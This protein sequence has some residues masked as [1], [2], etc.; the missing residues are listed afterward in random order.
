MIKLKKMNL[1]SSVCNSLH[2]WLNILLLVCE[3][4]EIYQFV[5]IDHYCISSLIDRIFQSYSGLWW[6]AQYFRCWHRLLAWSRG[7]ANVFVC[8]SG[9]LT[10]HQHN[11]AIGARIAKYY[12]VWP[13][14]NVLPGTLA[15]RQYSWFKWLEECTTHMPLVGALL[16][17]ISE[18]RNLLL[19]EACD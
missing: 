2:S 11:M 13:Q 9:F 6:M 10:A 15:G 3:I 19:S 12:S 16:R 14:F 8:L 17:I 7:L 1:F 5:R 4:Y 18:P